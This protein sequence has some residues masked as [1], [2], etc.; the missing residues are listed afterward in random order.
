MHQNTGKAPI[1]VRVTVQGKRAELSTGKSIL[2]EQWIVNAGRMKGSSEEARTINHFLDTVSVRLHKIFEDINEEGGLVT[3]DEIKQR[4]LGHQ[5]KT[6]SLIMLFEQH[7]DLMKG[8]IGRGFSEGTWMRYVITMKHLKDY[9]KT[10]YKA[11]DIAIEKLNYGF[12]SGL[13]YYLK[14]KKSIGHN[15]AMKYLKNVKKIVLLARKYQWID[16]DPF[17]NFKVT[18]MEVN[19]DYLTMDEITAIREKEFSIDRLAHVR[20]VFIFCCFTGLS[21]SDVLNLTTKD[22]HVGLDGENWI[23][24]NRKKTGVQSNIP[25]LPEAMKLIDRYKN[26]LLSEV[27]GKL[28]PVASN[29][30]MN[31]YLKEIGD[32]CGIN[33]KMTFHMARHTFAT[34][35]TLSNGVSMETV[36]SMLG[37]KNLKTTQIYAKVVQDK[38]SREMKQLKAILNG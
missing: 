10:A 14:V 2:P 20:D 18:Q 16:H 28:F 11:E 31:A 37:H 38:V 12:I 33:K 36:G 13:E 21:Y 24:I 19:K 29:Q 23:V 34:T 26:S 3:S 6:N 5:K 30:K 35:I 7:N 8:Q 4:Y 9:L 25:L 22:I 32:V 27:N 15:T 17:I 1:Y